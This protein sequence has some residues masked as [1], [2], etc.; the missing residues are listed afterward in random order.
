[1]AGKWADVG[2][3]K[4]SGHKVQSLEYWRLQSNHAGTGFSAICFKHSIL[5]VTSTSVLYGY[6]AKA[7]YELPKW[8]SVHIPILYYKYY[9][10]H[11]NNIDTTLLTA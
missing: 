7:E 8:L 2:R 10:F 11:K 3:Q 1:M 6:I 4:S 5:L 9:Q